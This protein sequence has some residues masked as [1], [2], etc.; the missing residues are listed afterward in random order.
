[1]GSS[2]QVGLLPGSLELAGKAVYL[3][4]TPALLQLTSS[5]NNASRGLGYRDSYLLK[6]DSSCPVASWNGI[7]FS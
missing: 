4:E 1:M 6:G 3:G 2:S 7:V 5:R